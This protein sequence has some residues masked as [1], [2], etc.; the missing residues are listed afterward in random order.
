MAEEAEIQPI[1]NTEP[2]DTPGYKPPA[3]KSLQEIQS[4]DQDDESLVRY[5][6]ALLAGVDSAASPKDDP[7][8]VV[9]QKMIFVSEGR[10][11]I[12]LDLSGD[13]SMLKKQKITIKE[14]V[15]FRLKIIF[16]VQHEIISGLR[17]HHVIS[18]KQVNVDKQQ[19]MVGSYGPKAEP[20]SYITPVDEAPK[21]M[22]ARGD[23]KVKS[24]FLDDDKNIHLQ[25][26]WSFEIKKN[27]K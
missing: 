5:K 22:I 3:E 8:K 26:E 18:R 17:Y 7:R 11:D 6:Q 20:Y 4:L 27:W 2:E 1:D 15:E 10:D 16:K 21:G 13:I 19:Y 14:G 24:K 23:Y 12:V 25:W 9:V